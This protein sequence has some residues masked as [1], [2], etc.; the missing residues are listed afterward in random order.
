MCKLF[1]SLLISFAT[2]VIVICGDESLWELYYKNIR[3]KLIHV[4]IIQTFSSCLD[5]YFIT[6]EIDW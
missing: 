6:D 3:E 5:G 1:A 4:V 2:Y